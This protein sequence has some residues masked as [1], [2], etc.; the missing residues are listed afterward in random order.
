MY[1]FVCSLF[2]S[3]FVHPIWSGGTFCC[4]EVVAAPLSVSNP[5]IGCAM[6][7]LPSPGHGE[8]RGWYA[9]GNGP[10]PTNWTTQEVTPPG[11]IALP[12]LFLRPCFASAPW[13]P[14][15]PCKPFPHPNGSLF[16][17]VQCC[18]GPP[19][20]D[21]LSASMSIALCAPAGVFSGLTPPHST[22]LTT[23]TTPLWKMPRDCT[24][25][26]AVCTRRMII[27]ASIHSVYFSSLG[28]R[29]Y[30]GVQLQEFYS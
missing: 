21:R 1:T 18:P 16:P 8:G 11:I 2:D 29:V 5:H 15:S 30:T 12:R 22:I 3:I 26:F 28:D 9:V 24:L 23:P 14:F 19:P 10:S 20:S 17:N 27:P 13:F 25:N 6:A 7:S 4:S